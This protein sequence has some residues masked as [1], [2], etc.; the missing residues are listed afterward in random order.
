MEDSLSRHE[1]SASGIFRVS[2]VERLKQ[3][4]LSGRRKHSKLL[5]SLIMFQLW[6]AR[7]AQARQARPLADFAA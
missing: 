5:F 4:H 2:E 1:I 3:E 7:S 6:R